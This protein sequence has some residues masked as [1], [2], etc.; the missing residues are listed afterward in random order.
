MYKYYCVDQT[1]TTSGGK[2]THLSTPASN[3]SLVKVTVGFEDR[4]S[5]LQTDMLACAISESIVV[6]YN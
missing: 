3:Y 5:Y 6:P 1:G 2:I 4:L